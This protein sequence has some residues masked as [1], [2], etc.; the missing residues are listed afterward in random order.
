VTPQRIYILPTISWTYLSGVLATMW[1]AA[2][3]QGNSAAY[4]LMFFLA[5]LVLV[6][7]VHAH[8]ALTGLSVQIGRI[9]PVFAGEVAHALVEV[10]N[11]SRRSRAALEVAPDRHVFKEPSHAALPEIAPGAAAG[12]DL[13]YRTTRRGR[14]MLKRVAVTTIYPLGFFRSWRYET[15]D[16]FCLVFPLPEGSLPL[17]VGPAAAAE[18]AGG[19]GLGGDDFA[20]TRPYQSGESQRHVDWRAVARGQPLLVKQF[21]GAGSR[22]VWL[23]YE[24]LLATR[25]VEVRLSQLSEWIVEAE[26]EG[27]FYGLRLPGFVAEPSRGNLHYQRC[28]SALA[29][30]EP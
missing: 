1:Y 5:S 21:A 26:R 2:I 25:D 29:E 3:S 20:G 30:F 22:R 27:Y 10:R 17:P 9:E 13:A 28:L 12:A 15:T 24:A 18:L 16:A 8:F 6:S 4:L 23:E 11:G 7:A 14:L 19:T